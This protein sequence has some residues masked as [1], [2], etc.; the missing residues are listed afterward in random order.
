MS[1]LDKIFGRFHYPKKL[2][3]VNGIRV[4]MDFDGGVKI[5]TK[6]L[7]QSKLI[8]KHLQTEGFIDGPDSQ[9]L[10]LK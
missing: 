10:V 2:F 9:Q 6:N 3:V 1:L 5:Y 8:Y 7:V 4:E